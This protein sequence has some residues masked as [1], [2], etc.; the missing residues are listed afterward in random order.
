VSHAITHVLLLTLFILQFIAVGV[1]WQQSHHLAGR[2]SHVSAQS[3]PRPLRPRT[4]DD[5]PRCRASAAAVAPAP[6]LSLVPYSQL[7][8]RRGRPKGIDTA[9]F[10]CPNPDCPYF[11]VTDPAVHAL[12]GYGGHGTSLF[13]QDF[14]C[15]GCRRKFS[16]RYHT[17][18]YRLKTSPMVVAQV[19]HAIAEGL[20]PRAAARVFNVPETT[21]R[22]WLCRAGQHSQ[23]LHQRL[24]RGLKLAHVQLDELRVKLHGVV[25][26]V[27]L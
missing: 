6:T 21:V 12:V 7:K 15:Q 13:I 5:C 9:G 23:A 19:L 11:G 8:N 16:A 20:S 10:A 18:L 14:R 22:T 25:N 24:L 27:W 4:P 2:P 1:W 17:P 26:P 3:G